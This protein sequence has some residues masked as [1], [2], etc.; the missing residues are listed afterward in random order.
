MNRR[1]ILTLIGGAAVWPVAARAQSMPVIGY[2]SGRSLQDSIDVL[3][4]FRRGLAET[5]YV[6]GR[7][8]AIEYR[9][10]EGHYD[11]IPTMVADLVQRQV[12]VIA[13]P[14]TTASALAAKAATQTIP[15]VVN[16]G[17]D[18]VAIGLVA[19]LNRPGGNVTGVSMLQNAAAAKRLELLHEL[20]PA[21]TSIGFLVNST[22][23][24]FA[25]AE[26]REVQSAARALGIHLL[27]LNA[28]SASEIEAAFANLVQQRAGALLVG[29]D[30]FFISQID[31]L[32]ALA[33]RHVVPVI[34][35]YLE[36]AVAGGLMSYGA[37]LA[38]TQ[39][40]VGVYAGRILMGEKAA[41]LPVQQVTKIELVINIKTAKALGLPVPLALLTRADEV[42]E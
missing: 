35:P 12:A 11:R 2:L 31:Q 14:N 40:L 5:G 22:N 26:T 37:N 6:E 25:E 3:A 23:P 24:G 27:V 8:V 7:N 13:V 39:R 17:G 20:V 15:I 42:I 1:N 41:E 33:G 4:D 30:V 16:V 19:S 21:A 9:W 36:Q 38:D 34:Y 32:I 10:V 29:G 18:P 28:S